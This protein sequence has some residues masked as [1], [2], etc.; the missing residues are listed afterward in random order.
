MKREKLREIRKRSG[1]SVKDIAK[2]IGISTSH[3]YKIEEGI[4]NPTL[5]V[6]KKIAEMLDKNIDEIFFGEVLD[7]SSNKNVRL[8][9]EVS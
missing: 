8:R 9:E 7:D 3:Y 2:S 4:R 1:L 6:A 5:K